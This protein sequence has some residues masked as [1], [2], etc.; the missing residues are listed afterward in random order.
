PGFGDGDRSVRLGEDIGFR[1]VI[2]SAGDGEG[3]N[4]KRQSQT[5]EPVF[6]DES[7]RNGW[8]IGSKSLSR[9]SSCNQF[10]VQPNDKSLQYGKLYQKGTTPGPLLD[11]EG[12]DSPFCHPEERGILCFGT[13]G[14]RLLGHKIPPASG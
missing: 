14:D 4:Q 8:S 3:D 7:Y 1:L 9:N 12:V 11:K 2:M 5:F 13:H 6:H 10:D